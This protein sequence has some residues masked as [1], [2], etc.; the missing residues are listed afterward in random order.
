MNLPD[1]FQVNALAYTGTEPCVYWGTR[2]FGIRVY[3]SG[4][5]KY[6]L[7]YR[8][9][10]RKRLLTFGDFPSIAPEKAEDMAAA[11]RLQVAEGTDPVLERRATNAATTAF[12]APQL[13]A[14]KSVNAL[15]DAY[16][17]LHASKKKS[18]TPTSASLS[19]LSDPP[20]GKRQQLPSVALKSPCFTLKSARRPLGRR[21]AS[22]R[23]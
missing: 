3:P 4:K 19:G 12:P 7:S 23:S 10:G 20:G 11:Y 2:G 16:L 6:V 22:S 9:S 17:S 15:C 18:G 5:K 14:K 13:T 21:I 8:V 1:H